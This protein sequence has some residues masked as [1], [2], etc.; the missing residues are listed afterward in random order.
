MKEITKNKKYQNN[1]RKQQK[2]SN[3]NKGRKEKME[4]FMQ[5][6]TT[7]IKPV[8][9]NKKKNEKTKIKYNKK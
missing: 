5:N 8:I 1:I 3:N 4:K 6:I 2:I 9:K 7:H